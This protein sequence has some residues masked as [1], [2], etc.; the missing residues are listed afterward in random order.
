MKLLEISRAGMVRRHLEA[1]LDG[2][3]N[4]ELTVNDIVTYTNIKTD[5]LERLVKES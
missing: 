2:Y 5:Q 1:L 3:R 4:G